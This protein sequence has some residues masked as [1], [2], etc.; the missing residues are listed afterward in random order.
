MMPQGPSWVVSDAEKKQYDTYFT[1]A[2]SNGD[3]FVLGLPE[4]G[5]V[6]F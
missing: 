2:D 5:R 6:C 1:T 4:H 3:G